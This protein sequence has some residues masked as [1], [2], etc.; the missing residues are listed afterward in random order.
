[1]KIKD[2]LMQCQNA[3]VEIS[4]SPDSA[5]VHL[6]KLM[7]LCESDLEKEWLTFLNSR[8]GNLPT[9]GQ[10]MIEEC[11]TRPDFYYK[12]DFAAIYIDGNPHLDPNRQ[13]RDR[14]QTECMKNNGYTVIRFGVMDDWEKIIQTYP[15]I[16]GAKK[17][18]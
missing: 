9:N 7:R 15:N 17:P 18:E 14:Q 12:G 3:R 16:F 6:Q 10:C 4:P 5:S 8:K 2:F 13:E 11:Q 1:M